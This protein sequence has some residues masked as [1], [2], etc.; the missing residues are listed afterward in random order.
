MQKRNMT[1][2]GSLTILSA[3]FSLL[4]GAPLC[5]E[6]QGLAS[7][8]SQ[9]GQGMPGLQESTDLPGTQGSGDLQGKRGAMRSRL[10][11]RFQQFEQKKEA[12]SDQG[13]G[14]RFSAGMVVTIAGVRVLVWKP[15]RNAEHAPA[16]TVIFSHGFLGSENQS[17]SI[18]QALANAGYLVIAPRHKDS[19][20]N[21]HGGFSKPDP[22]FE[23]PSRWDD[24]TF[25]DRHD[26][27]VRLIAG[28][29]ADPAW[30]SQIDWSKLALA[31]H[32]LGGYTVLSLG[33]ARPQWKIP[34]VKAILALSPYCE[35]LLRNGGLADLGIPIMY[36]GGTTDFG[37][38]PSLKRPGGAFNKTGSPVYFVEFEQ[39]GHFG[40][41]NLNKKEAQLK[42]IN[43]YTVSFFD[44]Y[45][46]GDTSAHPETKLDG[47][48]V[49]EVK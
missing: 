23:A 8:D 5:A 47:V 27:I 35:P 33:G 14:S 10:L 6:A 4:W 13:S 25:K 36:Q 46:K 49:L 1:T 43:F 18:M 30:N 7:Q 20:L 39:V 12:K 24:S 40:W 48:K 17:E 11:Q 19:I 15:V 45:V 16:P 2:I 26:D 42:L 9:G 37:I 34:G 21:G 41:T 31:G 22:P 38:T 28:L 29:H 3:V 32:S 44:K